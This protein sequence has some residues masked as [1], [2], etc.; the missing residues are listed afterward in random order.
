MKKTL[1]F[2]IALLASNSQINAMRAVPREEQ[3][4]RMFGRAITIYN[5]TDSEL[6]ITA[7]DTTIT[8][9][10]QK[11]MPILVSKSKGPVHISANVEGKLIKGKFNRNQNSENYWEVTIGKGL[12]GHKITIT[13]RESRTRIGFM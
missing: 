8:V 1:L 13:N 2:I 4:A 11:A 3:E 7:N 5:N 10:P 9:E 12:L 6:T